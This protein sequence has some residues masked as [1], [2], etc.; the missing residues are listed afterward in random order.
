MLD[1]TLLDANVLKSA[2]VNDG[3]CAR[4]FHSENVKEFGCKAGA[5]HP[6]QLTIELYNQPVRGVVIYFAC[7]G[8]FLWINVAL[9]VQQYYHKLQLAKTMP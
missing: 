7:V 3:R 6:L 9:Y 4:R 1:G 2:I 5:G 8:I